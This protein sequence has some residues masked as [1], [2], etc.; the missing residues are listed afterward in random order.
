MFRS[1]LFAGLVI[2]SINFAA[3]QTP[4]SDM[5][6]TISP[7]P[8]L[9]RY[10]IVMSPH[11]ARD[12]FLLDTETG[13]VWQLTVM[14]YLNGEPAV[15]DLMPRIDTTEDHDKVVGDYGPKAPTASGKRDR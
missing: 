9:G 13:R 3:A 8:T 4:K 6:K 1:T 10:Q 2:G 7:T 15:W 14:T 5:L 11:N 12:T